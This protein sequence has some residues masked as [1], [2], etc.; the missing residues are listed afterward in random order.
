[1]TARDGDIGRRSD[2]RPMNASPNPRRILVVD[3]ECSLRDLV[4][5]ALE[6][7]GYEVHRRPTGSAPWPR[8]AEWRPT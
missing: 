5:T 1:M 4:T 7:V 8:S 3:D 2:T 6:F